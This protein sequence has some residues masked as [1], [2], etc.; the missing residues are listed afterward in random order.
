MRAIC[1]I[2][3]KPVE[4]CILY[5]IHLHRIPKPSYPHNYTYK[6]MINQGLKCSFGINKSITPFLLGD[7]IF[8][9]ETEA[10]VKQCMV[11]ALTRTVGKHYKAP[12]GNCGDLGD[13]VPWDALSTRKLWEWDEL[14]DY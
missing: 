8:N 2:E 10:V 4:C 13:E 5:C 1:D 3:S 7:R 14:W 11:V 6:N 12:S 9:R